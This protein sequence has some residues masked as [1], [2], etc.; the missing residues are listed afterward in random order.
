MTYVNLKEPVSV[1][2]GSVTLYCEK[3]TLSAKTSVY[4]STTV[5]GIPAKTNKCKQLTHLSLSGRVYDPERP[6]LLVM[7]MNNIN[8]GENFNIVYKGIEFTGCIVTGVEAVDS[9]K[10]YVEITVSLATPYI[11]N[12]Y[13]G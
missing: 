12:V 2:I 7:M 1:K 8:G 10:D 9:G 11:A 5:T 4:H 3:M 13:K 6:M